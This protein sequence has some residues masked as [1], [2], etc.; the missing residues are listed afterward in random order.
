MAPPHAKAS[1]K[2]KSNQETITPSVSKTEIYDY[3]VKEAKIYGVDPIKATWI[4]S[5][6]SQWDATKMGDDGNSR[7]LWQISRIYHPEVSDA[8]A[9]DWKCSTRWSMQW[10]AKDPSHI[11]QWTTWKCRYAFYPDATSTLGSAPEGYKTPKICK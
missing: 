4:V 2:S 1:Q 11:F 7:G 6:E 3:L 9:M 8:C 10:I 5:K